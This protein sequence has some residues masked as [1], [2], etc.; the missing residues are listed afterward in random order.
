MNLRITLAASAFFVLTGTAAHAQTSTQPGTH[1]AITRATFAGAW[2]FTVDQGTLSCYRG[3]AIIFTADGKTYALNG[4]AQ[5]V[6]Q[7]LGYTWQRINAIWRDNPE[8]PGTKVPITGLINAGLKLC[9][10]WP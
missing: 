1:Q 10:H 3:K 5:S 7:G 2:P 9:K 8:I 6:G 4:A